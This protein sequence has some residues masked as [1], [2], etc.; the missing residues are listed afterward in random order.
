MSTPTPDIPVALEPIGSISRDPSTELKPS[1]ATADRLVHDGAVHAHSH[2]GAL[3]GDDL[4][5]K[6]RPDRAIVL[7]VDDQPF[8]GEAVRRL[9]TPHPDI[10]YHYCGDPQKALDVAQRVHP[11]V[12]L[13]DLVMPGVDGLDLV[14]E[15]RNNE[16][17]RTVPIVVLSSKE[18]AGT[19]AEAFS[20]GANDY[21]IKLPDPIELVARLRSHSVGFVATSERNQAYARLMAELSTAATYVRHLLP[22]PLTE[23][24]IRTNWRFIPSAS[25]GGDAFDYHWIDND[26]FA[27]VLL[28]VCGHGVGPALLSISVINLLRAGSL[29]SV[30]P[31]CPSSVLAALNE[32][33]PMRQHEGMFFTLWYGVYRPSDRT[34]RYAGAGH[35]PAI[36]L[37][38]GRGG[39]TVSLESDG[40]MIGIGPGLD[41]P[42]RE[43]VMPP[44]SQLYLYSDGI[45]EIA[46]PEGNYWHL[47]EFIASMG[48]LG[49]DCGCRIEE[50]LRHTH[51]LRHGQPYDDDVSMV[52]FTFA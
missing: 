23:G 26:H 36:V 35:P 38:R 18:D 42:S 34:L 16:A 22:S 44:N 1:A 37:P 30:D 29:S 4:G 52:E 21:L 11:T 28:D 25:L 27:M 33:F 40:P 48:R 15:Y 8:M 2:E 46:D 9:L 3:P 49:A 39:N 20:R 19:K 41:Y 12:I 51:A 5:L 31:R 50:M 6:L 14:R 32:A 17:T 24:L 7:L 10:L 45:F 13:Q 43:Y 47:D